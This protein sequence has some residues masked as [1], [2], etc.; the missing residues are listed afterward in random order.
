IN[1]HFHTL[2]LD[3]VFVEDEHGELGFHSLPC[4]TNGDVADIL[5]IATTRILRL[6][7]QSGVVVD[8]TVN[9]VNAA[10][11]LTDAE[12][13][14]AEL[15]VGVHP[16]PHPRRSRP[17]PTRPHPPPSGPR[18]RIRC[19]RPVLFKDFGRVDIVGH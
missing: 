7:R 12:P 17:A 2:A 10:E 9:T 4:L 1:L 5:P 6:L 14:L 16:G 11:A 19:M 13:S 15:A 8:D 18:P 3:G